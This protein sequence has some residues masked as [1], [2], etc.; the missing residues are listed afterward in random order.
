MRLLAGAG[1]EAA[2]QGRAART[3]PCAR[4]RLRR[5]DQYGI[6][7]AGADRELF[8]PRPFA[9]TARDERRGGGGARDR[10]G[11]PRRCRRSDAVRE[12]IVRYGGHDL[13]AVLG[14]RTGGGVERNTP[15]AGTGREDRKSVMSGKR[16][17]VRVDLGCRR[18]IKKKNKNNTNEKH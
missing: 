6:L 14:R 4:T 3:R 8:R 2:Q 13:H 16:G 11:Y 12:R 7:S 10:G 9:R 15:R 5:R 17:Y 1:D 18:F